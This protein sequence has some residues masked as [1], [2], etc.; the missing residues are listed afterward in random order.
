M[1][2]R[3]DEALGEVTHE[4][5]VPTPEARKRCLPAGQQRVHLPCAGH[6]VHG[7]GQPSSPLC[8]PRF[9]ELGTPPLKVT[10]AAAPFCRWDKTGPTWLHGKGTPSGAMR[11]T[12]HWTEV[13]EPGRSSPCVSPAASSHPANVGPPCPLFRWSARHVTNTEHSRPADPAQG[14][15]V[16]HK[17]RKMWG[18]RAWAGSRHPWFEKVASLIPMASYSSGRESVWESQAGC[19]WMAKVVSGSLPSSETLLLGEGQVV[20]HPTRGGSAEGPP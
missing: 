14:S 13:Y 12:Q 8:L 20:P 4:A 1:A 2:G 16:G 3:S 9:T 11:P 15:R 17:D 19:G 18:S 5:A 10:D 6:R 7:Q